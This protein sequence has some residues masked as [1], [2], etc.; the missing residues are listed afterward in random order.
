MYMHYF[1]TKYRCFLERLR[2]KVLTFVASYITIS[3]KEI[4]TLITDLRDKSRR[5]IFYIEEALAN[6]W[7]IFKGHFINLNIFLKTAQN[8]WHSII[9]HRFS[10]R[11]WVAMTPFAPLQ[12]LHPVGYETER[13]TYNIFQ[14]CFA[15]FSKILMKKKN[16]NYFGLGPDEL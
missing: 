13:L 9:K 8:W 3:N 12:F 10:W 1:F 16:Y 4:K 2:C 11:Y 7:I 15:S 14:R 6:C 5:S